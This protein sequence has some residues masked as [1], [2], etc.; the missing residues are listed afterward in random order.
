MMK[1]MLKQLVHRVATLATNVDVD[2]ANKWTKV[3]I[4]LIKFIL[5][6]SICKQFV[7]KNIK[8]KVSFSQIN[9]NQVLC[10]KYVMFT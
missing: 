9:T 7:S 10:C 6:Y 8:E 4:Q 5:Q 2:V 1:P 3:N